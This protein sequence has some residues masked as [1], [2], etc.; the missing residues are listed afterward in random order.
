MKVKEIYK[1]DIDS[2][3]EKADES[4]YWNSCLEFYESVEER[5][6]ENLSQKQVDWLNK[7]EENLED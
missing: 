7:I 2:L 5:D 4:D 3:V 6:L 1:F